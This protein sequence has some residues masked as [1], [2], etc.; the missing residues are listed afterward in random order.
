MYSTTLIQSHRV[1]L[2]EFLDGKSIFGAIDAVRPF[3]FIVP[4][5]ISTLDTLLIMNYGMWEV[6]PLLQV[7]DIETIAKMIVVKEGSS[8]N[9]YTLIENIFNQP[10]NRRELTETIVEVEERANTQNDTSKVSAFNS[11]TMVNDGGSETQGS[12]NL[13]GER[14]RTLVDKQIDIKKS[15]EMLSIAAKDAIIGKVLKDVK[16]FMTLSIY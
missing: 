9:N 12:N 4:D 14:V 5:D 1:T 11:E 16:Q 6:Y 13:D 7:C 15:Y 2:M 8:W 3:P 10:D